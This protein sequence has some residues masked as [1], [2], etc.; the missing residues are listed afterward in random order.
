M[1]ERG[2]VS[3][4]I[5]W[6]ALKVVLR[7][8]I[9]LMSS[10]KRNIRNKKE[11]PKKRENTKWNLHSMFCTKSGNKKQKNNV[12]TQEIRKNLKF[13]KHRY[14]LGRLK[15][16]NVL[17]WN[18]MNKRLTNWTNWNSAFETLYLH[19]LKERKDKLE[20]IT[21]NTIFRGKSINWPALQVAF[22]SFRVI[23]QTLYPNSCIHLITL[24]ACL[25]TKLIWAKH[26]YIPKIT[27]Q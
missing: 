18:F 15:S 10:Y 13:L 7:V 22:W 27:I 16:M 20:L 8:K 5:L 24:T 4:P 21:H 17:A 12:K 25:D 3:P 1:N 26:N 14:Y 2:D 11:F 9:I 23:Q 6:D 19:L